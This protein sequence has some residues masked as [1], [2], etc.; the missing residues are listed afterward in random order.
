MPVMLKSFKFLVSSFFVFA[1]SLLESFESGAG[2]L[3][4]VFGLPVRGSS[5]CILFSCLILD[6]S[7]DSCGLFCD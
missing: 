3:F 6:L 2:V 5:F 4:P 1:R 7:L